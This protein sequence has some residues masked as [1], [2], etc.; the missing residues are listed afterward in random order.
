MAATLEQVAQA[1]L[2]S[3]Q[4]MLAMRQQFDAEL[5][6]MRDQVEASTR[7]GPRPEVKSIDTRVLGKP[8]PFDG[9]TAWRDWSTVFRAYWRVQPRPR[10]YDGQG[11]G[12]RAG[13]LHE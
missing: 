9:Q 7:A 4:T 8:E 10:T 12:K 1:L 11:R 6:G 3:Q 13:L 2:D 5:R